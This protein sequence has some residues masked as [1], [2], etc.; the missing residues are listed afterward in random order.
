LLERLAGHPIPVTLGE[1]RPGDQRIYVSDTRKAKADFGWEPRILP[2]AG[3]TRL[4]N[5]IV[6]NKNLFG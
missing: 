2:E 5:W 1:W 6:A 3:M 4:W